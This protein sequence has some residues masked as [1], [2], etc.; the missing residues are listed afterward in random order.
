[1]TD[2]LKPCPFCGGKAEIT[3]IPMAQFDAFTPHCKNRKC[4]AFYIGYDDEGIYDTISSA[5]EA[6]NRRAGE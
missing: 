4:V 1:M 3:Q 6:W 5:I 2:K